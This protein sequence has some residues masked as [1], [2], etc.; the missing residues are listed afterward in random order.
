MPV[1]KRI[2][3][4]KTAAEL[5]ARL[6]WARLHPDVLAW[7]DAAPA[8]ARWAVGFS[9]G[10]DSLAL[11]LLLWANWSKRR[12]R[13]WVLH[14]NHRLR[15]AE[16]R[17]DVAFCRRVCAAL[18]VKFIAGEWPGKHRGASEADARAARMAFFEKQSRVIWL[19][20]QLDDI[21]ETMLMRLA[22]G[23]GAG[24]LAAPRPVQRLPG[25]RVHLRP[26][27]TVRKSEIVTALRATGLP[28]RADSSNAGGAFFR[29]RI[30]RDVLPIWQAV[31]QRDALSGAAR[32]RMLLEEDD[33]ALEALLAEIAPRMARGALNLRRL[34]GKPRALLRRALHGWLLAQPSA[35]KLSRQGFDVLLGSIER[36][37]PT[38]HSLGMEGF[39][40]IR[41]GVLRFERIGKVRR[42]FHRTAN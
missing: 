2:D 6:P 17:G 20:H 30:R 26:L 21:A 34:E 37:K 31:A 1:R 35:G 9:G 25:G 39:A 33:A 4:R 36:G 32:S 41:D 19:G 12:P 10:P 22:R 14:F 3:W 15:G 8:R 16:S 40:V 28:W 7:A 42:K 18:G 23:S 24:G 27:L 29:N 13:L 11:L 5:A 38:R